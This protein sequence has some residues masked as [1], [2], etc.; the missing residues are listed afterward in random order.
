M[1]LYEVQWCT[2]TAH[3]HRQH[4]H[5]ANT[6]HLQTA[7]LL[8]HSRRQLALTECQLFFFYANINYEK[9]EAD[10]RQCNSTI[11]RR[12]Y[13]DFLWVAESNWKDEYLHAISLMRASITS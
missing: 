4:P 13:T 9:S 1:E 12:N 3:A 7:K 6:Q 8:N 10:A 5:I 11:S 2:A